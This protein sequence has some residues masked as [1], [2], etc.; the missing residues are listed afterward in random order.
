MEYKILIDPHHFLASVQKWMQNRYDIKFLTLSEGVARYRSSGYAEF[1]NNFQN[2]V[3]SERILSDFP[4][5]FKKNAPF[6]EKILNESLVRQS[7]QYGPWIEARYRCFQNEDLSL[8]LLWNDVTAWTKALTY[9]GRKYG[10]PSL[11]VSHGIPGQVPVHGKVW[12]DKIS[13]FGD[14]SR[15][16][17]LS[18]GN[19]EDKIVVTGNPRWDAFKPCEKEDIGRIKENL[20]L[21]FHKKTIMYAPTWYHNFGKAD[22][23]EE[24]LMRDLKIV[25]NGI[26]RLD[27]DDK[28]ELA[29][30][31]H[32]GQKEIWKFYDHALRQE[33]LSFKIFADMSPL[34]LLQVSDVVICSG[35]MAVET[36]LVGKPLIH[37]YSPEPNFASPDDAPFHIVIY[38]DEM[39]DV[40][41]KVVKEEPEF[42]Q[43]NIK[44]FLHWVNSECDG[45][46]TER[47]ARLALDMAET[48]KLKPFVSP[49]NYKKPSET[50]YENARK[51]LPSMIE[52]TPE[53]ILEIGCAAG[54]M[55]Q[56]VKQH[57]DCEYIG[58][59][60]AGPCYYLGC[61]KDLSW[62]S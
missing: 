9:L 5:W 36:L 47:V 48:R 40:L 38:E 17:Y 46:A 24:S 44:A 3:I 56:F 10:V 15:Q 20:H 31:L 53:K 18:N 43:N 27:I 34:Q 12:A 52:G 62:R 14:S 29:I 8:I 45:K 4:I 22:N 55:G 57:F 54:A 28:V 58:A 35:S 16:F 37:L 25:I 50:Y 33:S 13:V 2:A 41:N 30:K 42:S 32:P 61:G 51:D 26:K 6:L 39:S 19:S 7:R 60:Q 23:P 1:Q 21:D 59:R 49:V 11:H